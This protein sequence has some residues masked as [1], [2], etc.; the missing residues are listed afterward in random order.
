MAYELDRDTLLD[1]FLS[2]YTE[3]S[4]E[5]F[6]AAEKHYEAMSLDDLK[7]EYYERQ[8]MTPEEVFADMIDAI[9]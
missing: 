7:E 1:Y 6:Q 2:A 9:I 5:E 3:E 8:R 4:K